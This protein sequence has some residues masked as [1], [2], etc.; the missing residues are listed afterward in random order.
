MDLRGRNC[1]EKRKFFYFYLLKGVLPWPRYAAS[2][3]K[4]TRSDIMSA[5]PTIK[6]INAGTPI[7]SR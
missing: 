6:P 2:A 5:T 4:A 7:S 1:F 3:G